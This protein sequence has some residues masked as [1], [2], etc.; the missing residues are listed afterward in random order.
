[1][2]SII[3]LLTLVPLGRDAMLNDA[4][5]LPGTITEYPSLDRF[6]EDFVDRFP[7]SHTREEIYRDFL[8]FLDE[9]G[10]ICKQRRIWIDGSYVTG[11]ENPN[12]IDVVIFIDYSLLRNNWKQIKKLLVKLEGSNLDIF[13][14]TEDNED[15][16]ELLLPNDV[17]NVVENITYWREFFSKDRSG[18]RKG[19]VQ[20]RSPFNERSCSFDET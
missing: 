5:Y 11:K 17:K 14:I 13:P 15:A 1:M 3:L 2:R 8:L 19:F 16:K 9:F 12:D 10:K 4:G 7:H 20:I 6:R 18:A